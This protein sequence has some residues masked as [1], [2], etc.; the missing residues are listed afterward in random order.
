MAHARFAEAVLKRDGKDAMTVARQSLEIATNL[1][2]VNELIKS[3]IADILICYSEGLGR[4]GEYDKAK[5][6]VGRATRR[7]SNPTSWLES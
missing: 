7:L 5:L 3:G 6:S 1:A 2:A 4:R